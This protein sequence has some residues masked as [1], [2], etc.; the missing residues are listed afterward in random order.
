MLNPTSCAGLSRTEAACQCPGMSSVDDTEE[1]RW[2]TYDQVAEARG[3]GKQSA[4][5]LVRR[6]GWR[7]GKDNRGNVTALVPVSELQP[8]P[9]SP[10]DIPQDSPETIRVIRE[11]YEGQ[12]EAL[13]AQNLAQT[14]LVDELR[15]SVVRAE[16]EA[17]TA[18]GRL[19]HLE[20]EMAARKD[21]GRWARLK[22]AWRGK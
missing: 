7:R 1:C 22:A 10:P 2:V 13:K 3:I 9:D 18:Q 19:R 8:S 17:A 20:Q 14:Q 11:I 5:R 16:L 12:V 6:R 21:S 4:V 15:A